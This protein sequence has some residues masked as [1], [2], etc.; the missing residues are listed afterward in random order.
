MGVLDGKTT[1]ITGG[2]GALGRAY[3]LAIAQA[4][5]AVAVSDVNLDTARVTADAI[6]KAGGKALAIKA[7]VTDAAAFEGLFDRAEAELGPLDV[8][9]NVAGMYTHSLVAEMPEQEWDQVI[10]TNLKSVFLGTRA[11][12]RRMLPRRRGVIL[13]VASGVGVRGAARGAHYAASKAGIIAFTR[14]VSLELKDS[15]VRINCI[16]PGATDS[17]LWRIGRSEGEIRRLLA[18]GNILQPAEFAN[19]VV[20]LVSDQSKPLSGEFIARDPHR[21]SV[22]EK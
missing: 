12:L 8:L 9:V 20:W 2:G 22:S 5:A 14:S 18:A 11:A 7:D 6:A 4:G 1:V 15:G 16:G 13:S 3:A 21:G 10:Q 19:V 17:A